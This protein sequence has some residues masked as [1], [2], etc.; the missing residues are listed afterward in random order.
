MTGERDTSQRYLL[1]NGGLFARVHARL[2]EIDESAFRTSSISR[3]SKGN[4]PEAHPEGSS[5]PLATGLQE[6]LGSLLDDPRALLE[7]AEREVR[8]YL[9]SEPFTGWHKTRCQS[10]NRLLQTWLDSGCHH[11]FEEQA[12]SP[13]VKVFKCRLCT[14]DFYTEIGGDGTKLDMDGLLRCAGCGKWK[15]PEE[16]RPRNQSTCRE[17]INARSAADRRANPER[18][19]GYQR[20]YRKKQILHQ[21]LWDHWSYLQY[22]DPKK[23]FEEIH[24]EVAEAFDLD[25]NDVTEELRAHQRLIQERV[26]KSNKKVIY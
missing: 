20:R 5:L 21:S 8:G 14:A 3:P 26:Q 19:A 9:S 1:G 23:S 18:S 7:Q 16:F 24:L 2:Q 12:S 6:W 4:Q 11:E 13:R 15:L 10:L 22:L 25:P 17:C